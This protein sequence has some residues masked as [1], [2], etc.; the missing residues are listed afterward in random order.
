MKK[1]TLIALA[2]SFIFISCGRFGNKE[3]D[4]TKDMRI[5]CLSKHLTEYVFALGKGH[6]IVAVDL[7]STYPDSAMLLK[8]VG[9]HRAL[10]PEG[11]IAMNPDLVIHSNDI[12]PE[13]VLPQIIKAGL[14]VKAFGGANTIDSA[15]ILLKQLGKFF[16]V[17]KV[18]DSLIKKM[19]D[20]IAK[21]ADTLKALQLTDSLK[22]MIIHFGQRNNTYFVMSGRNG[23]GDK[24]IRLAGCTPATYNGKGARGM[25]AEAVAMANPDIIIATDFG[26]DRMGS[27]DKFIST[28]PGVA[29]TNAG[30]NKRIV[31]FEEH[32]LIYFGPR[33]GDNVIK[34]INLLHPS[35][36][37]QKK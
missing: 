30:K 11:I 34:L 7:T 32:D 8:T 24:M 23:V 37:A 3:M 12:G 1:L 5:V 35:A 28:V 27:M 20:G 17:E 6:N 16:G 9:Y 31:R 36:S 33:T 18:A 13:N 15:R 22:V 4:G 19:D 25:S 10:N 21:A 26:Y 2:F 14:N 29:L